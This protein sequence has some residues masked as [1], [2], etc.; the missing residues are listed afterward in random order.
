[1]IGRIGIGQALGAIWMLGAFGLFF[2]VALDVLAGRATFVLVPFIAGELAIP[3]FIGFR[4]IRRPTARLARWSAFL[5]AVALFAAVM[6][7]ADASVSKSSSPLAAPILVGCLAL[8]ALSIVAA[9]RYRAPRIR[10]AD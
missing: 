9:I 7:A 8:L 10:Q 5:A 4:L 3:A 1:M 6:F 2:A